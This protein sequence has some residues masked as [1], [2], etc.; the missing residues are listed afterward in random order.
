[1]HGGTA[2]WNVTIPPNSQGRLS[3]TSAE[4]QRYTLDGVALAQSHKVHAASNA[5]GE[6]TYDFPA[7]SYQ[8]SVAQ[9][10]DA[11]APH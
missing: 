7:G 1:V 6:A 9:Q 2:T 5:D 3:L 8:L 11:D 4:A 10:A